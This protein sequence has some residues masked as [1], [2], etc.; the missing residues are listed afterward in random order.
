M[1]KWFPLYIRKFF[2]PLFAKPPFAHYK[3]GDKLSL[4][5]ST[6]VRDLLFGVFNR[7]FLKITMHFCERLLSEIF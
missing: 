7:F 5:N 2:I 4:N 3:T 6:V 1:L